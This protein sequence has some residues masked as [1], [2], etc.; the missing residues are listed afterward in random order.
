MMIAPASPAASAT[1]TLIQSTGA[2]LPVS[3]SAAGAIALAG[4]AAAR[5]QMSQVN[6]LADVEDLV[7]ALRE[8]SAATN[9]E[10]AI[11]SADG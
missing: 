6:T 1:P 7:S 11:E 3:G 4:A 9:A 2:D 5:R 10:A 8:Q